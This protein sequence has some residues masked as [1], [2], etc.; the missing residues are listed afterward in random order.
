M[1]TIFIVDDNPDM[2]Q[3]GADLLKSEGYTVKSETNPLTALKIIKKNPPHL[4]LLD[5]RMPHMDGYNVCKELK[6]DPQTHNIPVL[7]VSIKAEESDV[8]AGLEVGAEDY[9]RKP[10]HKG[11][12]LARIRTVLRRQTSPATS[13]HVKNGPL[14]MDLDRYTASIN[15][16]PLDLRPMEF[17]LLWY[18]LNREGQVMTHNAISEAVWKTEHLP[19]SQTVHFH[20]SQLRKKLGPHGKWIKSIKGI[21]YRVEIE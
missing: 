15:D 18:F 1:K 17:Q 5:I 4:I 13:A 2:I 8:V 10:Y 19:T 21:G 14:Q 7:M 6:K 11:E 16:Q 9:I 3:L 20:V 12:L